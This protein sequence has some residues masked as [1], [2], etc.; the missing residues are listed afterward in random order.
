[1]DG[2]HGKLGSYD[3]RANEWTGPR[4]KLPPCSTTW[5][6]RAWGRNN[7]IKKGSQDQAGVFFCFG[8][9]I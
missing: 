3:K 8:E 5:R 7:Q 4:K 1:M 9:V 6:S 2:A